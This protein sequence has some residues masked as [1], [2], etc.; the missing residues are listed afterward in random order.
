MGTGAIT[1]SSIQRS[2][3][4]GVVGD[5]DAYVRL[6]PRGE[7]SEFARVRNGQLALDFDDGGPNAPLNTQ[8]KSEGQGL[9]A[10]AVTYFAG[11][12]RISANDNGDPFNVWI[13]DNTEPANMLT[14]YV[15]SGVGQGKNYPLPIGPN[16]KYEL[17]VEGN[18]NIDIGVKVD[19]RGVERPQGVLVADEDFTIHA[20][21]TD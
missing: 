17:S 2:A 19:T 20:E 12:F 21:D 16:N 15:S 1:S 3:Q 10:D 13:E 11:V 8:G 7:N 5:A 18:T 14:F 6:V 4:G 9:N